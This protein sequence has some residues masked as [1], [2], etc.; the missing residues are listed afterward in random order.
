MA[1]YSVDE[2]A[3]RAGV[4]PDYVDR[5]VGLGILTLG[6]GFSPGDVLRT[7]WVES[8]ERS[9]VPLEGMAAAV[10]NG[11]LSLSFLNS[12]AFDRFAGLSTTTFRELSARTG[13]LLELL[14]VVRESF[15]YAQPRPEDRVREDELSVVPVLELQLSNGFRPVVIERWLRFCGDSLRRVA[16]TEADWWETEVEQPLLEGG[17]TEGE[18][19]ERQADLGSRMGPLI[20]QALLAMYHGQQEHAWRQSFVEH[21]EDALERAGL[22]R[23]MRH[24]PR[25]ASS[26]SPGTPG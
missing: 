1:G 8:L 25:A 14:M 23:R 20:E 2:V 10:R 17:M 22:Y 16:E 18:M 12:S 11:T 26:T 9:G 24:P 7:R 21:V 19:L 5:L 13:I 6:D 15:G 3:R 4:A